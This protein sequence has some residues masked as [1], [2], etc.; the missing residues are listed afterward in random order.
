M[1]EDDPLRPAPAPCIAGPVSAF[2]ANGPAALAHWHQVFE[3]ASAAARIG[4]WECR[5]SDEALTWS[6]A[7]YDLFG[8]RRGAALRRG[9]ILE[10]YAPGSLDHLQSLRR[11]AIRTRTGFRFDAEIVARTGERRWIR[12]TAAVDCRNG[13]PGRLYGM[14]QDVTAELFEAERLR[15]LA[16]RDTM[17]G[18]AN[19][20][21]FEQR[22]A[23]AASGPAGAALLVVDLDGFKQINDGH[24]HAAGDLCLIE[25][26]AR[27]T[28][29][30]VAAEL[31]ARIGGD[32]FVVLLRDEPDRDAPERFAACIIAALNKP[33]W[34]DGQSFRLG[35]SIGIARNGGCT[36]PQW[37]ARA[38]QALY[39]AK[40]AGRNT[41]R[42]FDRHGGPDRPRPGRGIPTEARVW[43]G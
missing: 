3:Q 40:A 1:P 15:T 5:L 12:I 8:L 13:A 4:L 43:I 10:C 16:E 41:F 14:K 37:L 2:A 34:R 35:A 7:V 30:C 19:R 32:E 27:L 36:G 26:G 39:A 22:L 11:N 21:L 24:G 6:G 31:V 18:L 23:A 42:S 20:A 9:A 25:A 33:V 29:I 38:D 17:T 28:R